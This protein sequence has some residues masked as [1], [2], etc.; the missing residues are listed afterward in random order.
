MRGES[1]R[2]RR[3]LRGVPLWVLA[4]LAAA[5][6][7]APFL[8]PYSPER[9]FREF[10]FKGPTPIV[11]RDSQG[12]FSFRPHIADYR[13]P[14]GL[15]Q[16]EELPT[17]LPIRFFLP[18]EPYRWMGFELRT[19]LFGLG[20]SD[21]R[22][23][24]LG[25]DNLGRDH[26]S[27]LLHGGRISLLA[28]LAG[29]LLSLIAG[30][31]VG[32]LSGYLAGPADAV[33]M[34]MVEALLALP[35]LFL[36]VGVRALFPVD[37]STNAAFWIIVLTFSLMGSASFARLMRGMVLTLKQR[38]YVLWA[39]AS[40]ASHVR[41]LLRHILPFTGNASLAYGLMLMPWFV[42][43]EVTLSFLGIGIQPPT[44]TW[45]NLL[46]QASRLSA[47]TQRPW[48]LASG[49]LLLVTILCLNLM[50]D[51]LK[52]VHQVKRLW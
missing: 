7:A 52:D 9:Q 3:V 37:L 49:L 14:D 2:L 29:V 42:L 43:G 12:R 11:F 46:A 26:F 39:R 24:L 5:L 34:R 25:A 23:F 8:S 50:A 33:S 31:A 19:R 48:M 38:E 51:R 1:V 28:G 10:P 32:A 13:S 41:I 44:P 22:I 6:W 16:Y 45:G 40:G 30:G 36:A 18:S 20:N 21:R 47:L 27:R 17:R 35:S 4:F 15:A